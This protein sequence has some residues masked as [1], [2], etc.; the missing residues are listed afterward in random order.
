VRDLVSAT[1]EPIYADPRAGD[2]KDSQ[3]DISKAKALL[4]YQPIVTF[5]D[6]LN[7]TVAWYRTSV[8]AA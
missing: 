3:A 1:V 8:T 2:V 6:G 7:Q 4:G 5:E